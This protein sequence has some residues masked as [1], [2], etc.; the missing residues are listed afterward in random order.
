[1]KFELDISLEL[2]PE[3]VEWNEIFGAPIG[4][5]HDAI[6]LAWLETGD[7]VKAL[8][9]LQDNFDLSAAEWTYI[10]V[11]GVLDFS[12][13][14]EMSNDSVEERRNQLREKLGICP[15]DYDNETSVD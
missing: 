11:R 4:R 7:T 3:G 12:E 1:M 8:L 9:W 14:F 15:G 6:E 10:L 13:W 5:A 2:N